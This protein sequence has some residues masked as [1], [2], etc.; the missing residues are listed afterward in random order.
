MQPD[1]VMIT[2]YSFLVAFIGMLGGAFYFSMMKSTMPLSYQSSAATSAVYCLVAAMVYGYMNYKYGIGTDTLRNGQYPTDLRYIDWLITTPL[3]V[4]KFPEMLGDDKNAG[5]IA[6]LVIAADIMM[7]LFGFAGEVSINAA[8][9]STVIGWM[10]FG[11][12][13]LAWLFIIFILYTS[14]TQAAEGKLQP[15]KIGLER[16][17]LFILIGWA[18]YP[19]GFL[20]TLMSNSPDVRLAR[21]LIYNFADLFNKVGFGMVAIFAVHQMMREAQI[22]KAMQA[23]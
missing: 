17:K 14:V 13:S 20:I 15:I 11:V 4:F 7:I 21:E 18:I 12:G 3:I 19:L 22:R 1:L 23:L 2:Q 16:L 6:L 10:T 8:K 9:G 5:K